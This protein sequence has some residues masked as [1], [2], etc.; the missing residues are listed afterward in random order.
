MRSRIY[1][2]I[3]RSLIRFARRVP[4]RRVHA[5]AQTINCA[6]SRASTRWTQRLV[7][8]S[9]DEPVTRDPQAHR[10]SGHSGATCRH[11]HDGRGNRGRS[12]SLRHKIMS[13]PWRVGLGVSGRAER[14]RDGRPHLGW[15]SRRVLA[16]AHRGHR[17]ERAGQIRR[18][19]TGEGSRG[20]DGLLMLRQRRA[21][22]GRGVAVGD[23]AVASSRSSAH[24]CSWV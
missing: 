16:G 9:G 8:R 18:L 15:P 22:D 20:G 12:C 21:V 2:P 19:P 23:R 4:R 7:P 13:G 17:V 6:P 11:S 14:V 10:P 24:G 3:W 1:S 5:I